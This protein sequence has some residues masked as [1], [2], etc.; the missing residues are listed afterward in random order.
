MKNLFDESWSNMSNEE[1]NELRKRLNCKE[2]TLSLARIYT[3][4]F[5]NRR[6]RELYGKYQIREE[7]WEKYREILHFAAERSVEIVYKHSDPKSP[8]ERIFLNTLVLSFLESDISPLY[9]IFTYPYSN[10]PQ[11]IEEVRIA[12]QDFGKLWSEYRDR[13]LDK[14][15][16]F[17]QPLTKEYNPSLNYYLYL[18]D[19]LHITIQACFPDL[20]IDNKSIRTD[21]LIWTPRSKNINLIVECDGYEFHKEKSA[22]IHDRK[23]DRALKFKGYDVLRYSGSEIHNNPIE[24]SISLV[25]YL[26]SQYQET[27][28]KIELKNFLNGF[29]PQ[30]RVSLLFDK[31]YSLPCVTC[32]R[33]IVDS[34]GERLSIKETAKYFSLSEEAVH[35]WGWNNKNYDAIIVYLYRYSGSVESIVDIYFSCIGSCDYPLEKYYFNQLSLSSRFD[36]I[37]QVATPIGF[38]VWILST[39][40][41]LRKGRYLYSEKAF[42]KLSYF[43]AA[44]AQI[45]CKDM[46]KEQRDQSELLI[47]ELNSFL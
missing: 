2:E 46:T 33:D 39:V 15:E 31:N 27:F 38:L 41:N 1:K 21:I 36:H 5:I 13:Y 30:K 32:K 10:A 9:F 22:F 11:E 17:P 18:S 16:A 47:Q 20:K 25:N 28:E 42:K 19:G 6:K 37:S 12:Q 43:I 26:L 7:Q 24:T 23:R 3:E 8:I 4:S 14:S 44:V 40:N 29:R 34:L 35:Q 45:V